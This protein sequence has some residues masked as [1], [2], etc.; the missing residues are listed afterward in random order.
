MVNSLEVYKVF[1]I[2]Y[3]EVIIYEQKTTSIYISYYLTSYKRWFIFS[4]SFL[5]RLKITC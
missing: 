3:A 1:I 2:E 5:S 4:P